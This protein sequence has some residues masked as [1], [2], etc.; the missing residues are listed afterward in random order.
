M[1]FPGNFRTISPIRFQREGRPAQCPFPSPFTFLSVPPPPPLHPISTVSLPLG[2]TSLYICLRFPRL[3]R[4][5]CRSSN[6]TK[7]LVTTYYPR[8]IDFIQIETFREKFWVV[9]KYVCMRVRVS[10]CMSVTVYVCDLLRR[11]TA[12]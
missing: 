2:P 5:E 1:L 9:W 12:T 10:V 4:F 7:I 8:L 6:R 11:C 3:I